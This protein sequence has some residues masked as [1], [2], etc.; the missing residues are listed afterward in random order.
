MIVELNPHLVITPNG[1]HGMLIA[2]HGL[3][4]RVVFGEQRIAQTY[5]LIDLTYYLPPKP[6]SDRQTINNH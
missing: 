4:G 1:Q 6:P 2:R 5:E 3:K